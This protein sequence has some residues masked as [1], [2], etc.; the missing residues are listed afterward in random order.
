[1]RNRKIGPRHALRNGLQFFLEG[2]QMR[3]HYVSLKCFRVQPIDWGV[4]PLYI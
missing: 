4:P 2:L 1:M 3:L